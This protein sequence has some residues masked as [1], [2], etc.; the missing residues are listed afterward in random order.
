MSPQDSTHRLTPDLSRQPCSRV[1]HISFVFQGPGVQGI[2]R[3]GSIGDA[4][5]DACSLTWQAVRVQPSYKT[6]LLTSRALLGQRPRWA[7]RPDLSPL[8]SAQPMPQG[9]PGDCSRQ[10]HQVQKQGSP[11]CNREALAETRSR[12]RVNSQSIQGRPG[13]RSIRVENRSIRVDHG[14]IKV[15]PG[16]VSVDPQPILGRSPG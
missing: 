6:A 2:T 9:G 14:S 8:P 12:S 4:S 5:H 15:D 7:E 3:P 10:A 1:S 13:S 11:S 16:R